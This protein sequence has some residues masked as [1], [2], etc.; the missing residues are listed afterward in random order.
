M[1]NDDFTERFATLQRRSAIRYDI[2]TTFFL[3][4]Q[5]HEAEK[6]P[7]P[8]SQESRWEFPRDK[9]R[10]QTVLGQGNFGQVRSWSSI[11]RGTGTSSRE[12]VVVIINRCGCKRE[13]SV[14][15]ALNRPSSSS[16][17]LCRLNETVSFPFLQNFSN[18]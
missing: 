4:F 5:C 2:P 1:T 12:R 17:S 10:L 16:S 18:A 6:P 14:C 3:P 13:N 9:L 8:S 11:S 15:E 7:P